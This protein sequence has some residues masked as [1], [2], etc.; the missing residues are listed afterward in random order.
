M[1]Y[2]FDSVRMMLE[3]PHYAVSH[4]VSTNGN[5]DSAH[6]GQPTSLFKLSDMSVTKH[7]ISKQYP[8]HHAIWNNEL[9]AINSCWKGKVSF[10]TEIELD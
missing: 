8:L 1:C 9:T 7:E 2:R 3:A 10:P 6:C 4:C 5:P